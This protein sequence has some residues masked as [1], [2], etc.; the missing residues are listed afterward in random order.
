V[1]YSVPVRTGKQEDGL[2]RAEAEGIQGAFVDAETLEQ[3]LSEIH[4]VIVMALHLDLPRA[5][6]LPPG[7]EQGE[8]LPFTV[9]VPVVPT[10]HQIRRY[11]SPAVRKHRA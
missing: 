2:W 11:V 10:E 8:V 4:E 7:V 5:E 9:T 3:A 1:C 6:P